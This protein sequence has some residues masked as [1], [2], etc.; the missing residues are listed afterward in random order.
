MVPSVVAVLPDGADLRLAHHVPARVVSDAQVRHAGVLPGD[1]LQD[2][3]ALRRQNVT[4]RDHAEG[5]GA[6]AVE[7]VVA[8]GFAL[9]V[10]GGL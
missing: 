2:G 5:R 3:S 9:A 4:D 10:F 8:P 1:P 6:V 7:N